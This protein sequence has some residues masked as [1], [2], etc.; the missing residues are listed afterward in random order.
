MAAPRGPHVAEPGKQI[1]RHR[2]G[3]LLHLHDHVAGGEPAFVGSAAGR[4][5]GDHDARLRV[6]EL[7]LGARLGRDRGGLQTKI[8]RIDV[9]HRPNRLRGGVA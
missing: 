3:R 4:D 6:G 8:G 2:H 7:V 9:L 5:F 1:R